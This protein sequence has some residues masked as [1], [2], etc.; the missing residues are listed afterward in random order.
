MS[1][2]AFIINP[3]AGEGF[4]SG[5][6][7]IIKK[8]A[9]GRGITPEIFITQR[10]GHATEI[11]AKLASENYKYIIGVGGDGTFNEVATPLVNNKNVVTGLVAAGTGNDFIQILGFPDRF[12]KK[13][14][15]ALFRAETIAMDAGNCNGRL[16]FNGMG[17]GFD[18]KVASENYTPEGEVKHGSK[19][20][21]IWHILKT[22]LFYKERKMIVYTNGNKTI[23]DCFINTISNGRRYAGGFYLTPQA[24]A[25]DGLFDICNVRKIG[26]YQRLRILTMVPSGKHIYDKR[27]HYYTTAALTLEFE[28][29]VPYHLDGE[30]YFDE[31]FEIQIIPAALNVI[32]NPS[33][34]HYFNIPGVSA[35]K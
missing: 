6:A 14:W 30:L 8:E 3:V 29:R 9:A 35:K 26:L 12:G 28:E 27:I 2:W 13:E 18:A 15:D 19:K 17:L 34:S 31:R 7:D 4:A 1:K 16:F 33:G 10:K 22:I 23:T 24:F 20:K 32:Y 11:A 21:Y 25:N 5:M